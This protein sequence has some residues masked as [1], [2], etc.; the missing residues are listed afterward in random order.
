M[1]E[2]G[3]ATQN[4]YAAPMP[5][6]SKNAHPLE[7]RLDRSQISAK[8]GWYIKAHD[9]MFPTNHAT[10]AGRRLVSLDARLFEDGATTLGDTIVRGFWD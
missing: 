2:L 8:I 1:T 5:G 6:N 9:R 10:F 7:G 4:K 3:T